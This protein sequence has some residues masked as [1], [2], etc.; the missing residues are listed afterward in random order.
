MTSSENASG[1]VCYIYSRI[2]WYFSY[3]QPCTLGD[4]FTYGFAAKCL[5]LAY[6]SPFVSEQE[7]ILVP[8]MPGRSFVS[9]S[10]TLTDGT[11]CLCPAASVSTFGKVGYTL[12]NSVQTAVQ[13]VLS[14]RLVEDGKVPKKDGVGRSHREL[15]QFTYRRSFSASSLLHNHGEVGK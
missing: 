7:Q 15:P 12:L 5:H 3:R 11:P 14:G 8:P 1:I 13:T 2:R 6:A 10:E 9:S 4:P